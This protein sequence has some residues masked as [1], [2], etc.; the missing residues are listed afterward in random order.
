M[1]WIRPYIYNLRLIIHKKPFSMPPLFLPT[2]T[3]QSVEML[4]KFV[5]ANVSFFGVSKRH[6]EAYKCAGGYALVEENALEK[7]QASFQNVQNKKVTDE[8]LT[9]C[10]HLLEASPVKPAV[11]NP[12]KYATYLPHYL[13]WLA[14]NISNTSKHLQPLNAFVDRAAADSKFADFNA[15]CDVCS[16]IE[17][18]IDECSSLVEADVSQVALYSKHNPSCPSFLYTIMLAARRRCEKLPMYGQ[19]VLEVPAAKL[20]REQLEYVL[21]FFAESAYQ[22]FKYLCTDFNEKD[23]NDNFIY[24][25][26]DDANASLELIIQR[27]SEDKPYVISLDDVYFDERLFRSN[28][29]QAM[30]WLEEKSEP[31][32][33]ASGHIYLPRAGGFKLD[34]TPPPAY[35]PFGLLTLPDKMCNTPLSYRLA[36][37]C[38]KLGGDKLCLTLDIVGNTLPHEYFATSEKVMHGQID[39]MILCQQNTDAFIPPIEPPN[40]AM[41]NDSITYYFHHQPDR[42]FAISQRDFVTWFLY[43]PVKEVNLAMLSLL[44]RVQDGKSFTLPACAELVSVIE[45]FIGYVL[46]EPCW[47]DE[48]IAK[49]LTDPESLLVLKKARQSM[50]SVAIGADQ[51]IELEVLRSVLHTLYSCFQCLP[52]EEQ[53]GYVRETIQRVF[54]QHFPQDACNT[55][56]PPY[57]TAFLVVRA[58]HELTDV[59]K[60]FSAMPVYLMKKA[61]SWKVLICKGIL[62]LFILQGELDIQHLCK[63]T[64]LPIELVGIT[65]NMHNRHDGLDYMPAAFWPHDYLFHAYAINSIIDDY[66][67][68]LQ[69]I[70]RVLLMHHIEIVKAQLP[71]LIEGFT[72]LKAFITVKQLLQAFDLLFFVLMHEVYGGRT[73]QSRT[74]L[75]YSTFPHTF[76][77]K[78][79]CYFENITMSSTIQLSLKEHFGDFTDE[80]RSLLPIEK[81]SSFPYYVAYLLLDAIVGQMRNSAP[82]KGEISAL[83]LLSAFKQTLSEQENLLYLYE[84]NWDRLVEAGILYKECADIED[85]GE[86]LKALATPHFQERLRI[87][88]IDWPLDLHTA[89]WKHESIFV[90]DAKEGGVAKD[91]VIL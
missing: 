90:Q 81:N 89:K 1:Y 37:P 86:R 27:V 12:Q 19:L 15:H 45:A 16:T 23:T 3:L 72:F 87:G 63:A 68:L 91:C 54:N 25:H 18:P 47:D 73:T 61:S 30:R 75:L 6:F 59:Y 53:S 40:L 65:L 77:E 84:D 31:L 82:E 44:A 79:R 22:Y 85:I 7:A 56:Y 29:H 20:N 39:K 55:A 67:K 42:L 36:L 57:L 78:A 49:Y 9:K 24:S 26:E 4:Y 64:C 38:K 83:D 34:G 2:N 66:W 51:C 5:S 70:D 32:M 52:F 43:T 35:L 21:N 74:R 71:T 10:I 46:G 50:L 58:L 14:S 48:D 11:E 13:F 28:I 41:S 33:F 60:Y 17:T 62:P 80:M 8:V 69:N 76:L 88:I